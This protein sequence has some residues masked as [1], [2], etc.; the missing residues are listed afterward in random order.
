MSVR[1]PFGSLFSPFGAFS[2]FNPR[3]PLTPFN[4]R[5]LERAPP[6]LALGTTHESLLARLYGDG[7]LRDI[8]FPNMEW[9]WNAID[10]SALIAGKREKF[11]VI[12]NVELFALPTGR[13]IPQGTIAVRNLTRHRRWQV[14]TEGFLDPDRCCRFTANGWHLYRDADE[15]DGAIDA[16]AYHVDV[17]ADDIRI[18]LQLTQGKVAYFGDSELPRG[19]CDNN[20][21]GVV[22]YWVTYRSRFGKPSGKIRLP[23]G[24]FE[25]SPEDGSVRF[26]HQSLHWS[27]RDFGGLCW[28]AL[29]EALIS[30]PA[31]RWYHIRFQVV[32]GNDSVGGLR[33]T[34]PFLNLVAYELTNGH[35]GGVLKRFAALSGD[36]GEV[37]NIDAS[38]LSFTWSR[39][40]IGGE[41]DAPRK[42]T[43]EFTTNAQ[44]NF[45]ISFECDS[46]QG[47]P[48]SYPIAGRLAF[49]ALELSGSACG[50][51]TVNGEDLALEGDGTLEVLDFFQALKR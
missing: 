36:D 3:S 48:V 33:E 10:F 5:T 34:N 45:E 39:E 31:W 38:T 6:K 51:V 43:I 24:E 30:R 26:D 27:P 12:T 41:L 11:S 16:G 49:E 9:W 1:S 37:L 29:G 15:A 42:T 46:R 2:P 14:Q 19:W 4:L 17:F 13:V 44:S 18:Q 28:E 22:P 21:E 35:T 25:I 50:T 7:S 8:P 40:K 20:P 47:F 32:P 23:D